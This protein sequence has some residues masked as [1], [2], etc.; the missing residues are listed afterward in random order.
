[1]YR[2]SHVIAP[3]PGSCAPLMTFRAE[4][5]SLQHSTLCDETP[6]SGMNFF[7]KLSYDYQTGQ[8]DPVLGPYRQP[9]GPGERKKAIQAR[10]LLMAEGLF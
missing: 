7:R 3:S 8:P 4:A 5:I 6:S 9:I 1:M 2:V 10:N